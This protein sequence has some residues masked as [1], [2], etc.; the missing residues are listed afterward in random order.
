MNCFIEKGYNM[1]FFSMEQYLNVNEKM[2]R[3]LYEDLNQAVYHQAVLKANSLYVQY[4]LKEYDQYY[5]EALRLL[6]IGQSDESTIYIK[7]AQH[8]WKEAIEKAQQEEELKEQ[9]K[10]QNFTEKGNDSF[11]Q[12]FSRLILYNAHDGIQDVYETQTKCRDYFKDL[13]DENGEIKDFY[14]KNLL[15][16]DLDNNNIPLQKSG[17]N[18]DIIE[19]I[20]QGRNQAQHYKDIK[21]PIS[22]E[23]F[24]VLERIDE[25]NFKG[26]EGNLK[27]YETLNFLGW[28]DYESYYNGMMKLEKQDK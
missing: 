24:Q 19:V 21:N 11:F 10:K 17:E 26:Y 2:V 4:S 28:T 18:L 6:S 15:I 1:G 3:S 5:K 20:W 13:K 22:K 9:N 16:R 23:C 7:R 27:S 25:S 14:Q 12:S 8:K